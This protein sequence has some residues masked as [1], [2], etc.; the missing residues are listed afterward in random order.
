MSRRVCDLWGRGCGEGGQGV[1]RKLE[2]EVRLP[3][4][5]QR[6]VPVWLT[7]PGCWAQGG[8]QAAWEQRRSWVSLGGGPASLGIGTP[9][10]G[11][12]GQHR[13]LSFPRGRGNQ[14]WHTPA[15][16]AQSRQVRTRS[17]HSHPMRSPTRS[18]HS[19]AA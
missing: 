14:H 10:G 2:A 11:P 6:P 12:A 13:G 5:L 15:L 19:A 17:P 1:L 8:Q 3:W 7:L 4:R 9:S 16:L 18:P